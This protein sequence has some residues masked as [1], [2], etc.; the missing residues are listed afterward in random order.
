MNTRITTTFMAALVGLCA[1]AVPT[2]GLAAAIGYYEMCDGTGRAEEATAITAAGHI[3][4]NVN[5]PDAIT[6]NTLDALF[7]TNCSNADY[8]GE[9]LAN[10]AAINNAV[11]TRGLI[12]VI[13]DRYVTG[14]S[15]ILPGVI[16]VRNFDDDANIDFPATSPI[17]TGPGGTL[18]NTSL[19]GGNSSSHGYVASATLP[20][21]SQVLA[22]RTSTTEG[23]T[24]TYPWG[25][26]RVI[27]STIPLD[28]YLDGG[29]SPQAF[30]TIYAPNVI[31]WAAG[32]IFTTCAAEGFTGAKLTLCRQICEIAQPSTKL[33]GLIKLYTAI[34]RQAPPC[35]R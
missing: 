8:G 33:V 34:Y 12:L 22:H 28:C 27:Y 16:G 31:A 10:L 7:V 11:Q 14:A 13:H 18:T 6:L 25:A 9:Y 32:Q 20:A 17:L 23:V 4:V 5:T 1:A 26:G 24:V 15:T 21:G 2:A 35:A 30:T 29:C 3:P 19:D